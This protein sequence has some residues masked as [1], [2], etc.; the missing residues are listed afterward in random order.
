MARQLFESTSGFDVDVRVRR[1]E[2]RVARLEAALIRLTGDRAE[3]A[4]AP[5]EPTPRD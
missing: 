5:T 2:E 3:P 1:L 4:D